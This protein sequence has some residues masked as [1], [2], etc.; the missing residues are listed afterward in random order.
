MLKKQRQARMSVAQ[1]DVIELLKLGHH[2]R[3]LIRVF[4]SLKHA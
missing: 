4:F 3:A 2:E 1:S